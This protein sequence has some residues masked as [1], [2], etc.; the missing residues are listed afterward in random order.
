MTHIKIREKFFDDKVEIVR[1]GRPVDW[2]IEGLNEQKDLKK[3]TLRKKFEQV[4]SLCVPKGINTIWAP[5]S[6]D[7]NSVIS[8][9]IDFT[10]EITD[11]EFRI[12]RGVM[13]D[14][15][16]VPENDGVFLASAD[17]PTI[18][19]FDPQKNRLVVAHAGRNCLLD[20]QLIDTNTPSRDHFSVVD[21]VI[22]KLGTNIKVHI[23][24][25]IKSKNF[26]HLVTDPVYGE[27][28][29]RML[30]FIFEKYSNCFYWQPEEG[31]LSLSMLIKAQLEIYGVRRI[32][33]DN[34]DTYEDKNQNGDL[35]WH[36]YSRDRTS[37]RNGILVC[38]NPSA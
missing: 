29:D 37:K 11:G 21:A 17:C 10:N 34:L 2:S 31:Q 4:K 12:Y 9:T 28:N 32:S 8:E 24:L 18:I 15:L 7:F 1:R 13:A 35:L 26:T 5:T 38:R 33:W 23:A 27:S 19:A 25:G 3:S 30:K 22:D 20:R 16:E 36:S 6:T 14:G